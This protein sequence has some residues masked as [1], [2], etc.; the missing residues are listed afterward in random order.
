MGG[1]IAEL[2]ETFHVGAGSI[3]ER[4]AAARTRMPRR[5]DDRRRPAT[6]L[7][8]L[9]PAAERRNF[10]TVAELKRKLRNSPFASLGVRITGA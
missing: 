9:V 6:M 4:Y 3:P 5:G 10:M 8:R 7:G 1:T 2:A